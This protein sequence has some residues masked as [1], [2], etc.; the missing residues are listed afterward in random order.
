MNQ[1]CLIDHLPVAPDP[2][3]A[4]LA[5]QCATA[6]AWETDPW[7]ARAVLT[8]EPITTPAIWDPCCGTGILGHALR[9]AGYPALTETDLFSWGDNIAGVDFLSARAEAFIPA[10]DFTVFMNPPF[11]KAT[12]FVDRAIGLGAR[13]V[14]CFQRFAW[15]ESA[16][17]RNWFDRNPP[18]RI[19]LCGDR[20]KVWMFHIP[21]ADRKGSGMQTAHAWFIWNRATPAS[22]TIVRRIWKDMK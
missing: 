2:A 13:D 4:S 20:A 17:R 22:D 11:S 8:V 7:A 6:E 3:F 12:E 18:N 10:D 5:E 9:R 14:I 1:L 16:T 21:P 15:F 19:Q